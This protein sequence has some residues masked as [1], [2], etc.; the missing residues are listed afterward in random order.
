LSEKDRLSLANLALS[1]LN[2]LDLDDWLFPDVG[3]VRPG[4]AGDDA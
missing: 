1:D 4:S 3:R 2:R